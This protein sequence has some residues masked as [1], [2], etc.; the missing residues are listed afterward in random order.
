[1]ILGF[2]CLPQSQD[3]FVAIALTGEKTTVENPVL[4][5]NVPLKGVKLGRG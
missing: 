1:L 2:I 4:C 5:M 3:K